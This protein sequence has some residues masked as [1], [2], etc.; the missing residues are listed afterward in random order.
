MCFR[1]TAEGLELQREQAGSL[2]FWQLEDAWKPVSFLYA[3]GER[4]KND[5]R[6]IKEDEQVKTI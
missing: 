2:S 5:K 6:K 3:V 4:M 1:C